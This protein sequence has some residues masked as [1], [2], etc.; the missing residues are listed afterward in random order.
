MSLLGSAFGRALAGGGAAVSSISAKFIDEELA[1]NRA[2]ALAELQRTNAKNIREDDDAFRNDPT[3]LERDRTNKA[4]D[5]GAAAKANRDAELAGLNDPNYRGAKRTAADEDSA[6]ATRRAAEAA[7]VL[8]PLE[9]EKAS[10]TAEARARA[11]AKYREPRAGST[12]DVQNKVKA[13]EEA[14]GRKLTEPEKMTVLGLVTKPKDNEPTEE[15]V[16]E[17]DAEGKPIGKKVTR[18]GPAGAPAPADDPTA[19]L[20]AGIERARQD[21]K[22][23]DAIKELRAKGATPQQILQAGITEDELRAASQ[24]TRPAAAAAA[25]PSDPIQ[26]MSVRELQRIASIDGHANQKRAK[27]ELARREADTEDIDTSGFGYR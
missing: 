16:T 1:M 23:A 2:Q 4:L 26:T 17:F 5:V 11:E 25:A 22:I 3:R 7:K 21:G 27:E 14:L 6:D 15:T 12:Q 13:V 19:K 10:L 20:R 18:K 9:V 8:T 24:P